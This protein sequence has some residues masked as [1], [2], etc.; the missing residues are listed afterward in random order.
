[1]YLADTCE[2]RV[3]A[4][5]ARAH[6]NAIYVNSMCAG[7]AYMPRPRTWSR[8]TVKLALHTGALERKSNVIRAALA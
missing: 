4:A 5:R 1:M 3:H 8:V 2:S 6:A 7:A